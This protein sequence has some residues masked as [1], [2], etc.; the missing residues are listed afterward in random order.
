MFPVLNFL[1]RLTLAIALN[2]TLTI[3]AIILTDRVN[4]LT[5]SPE[6]GISEVT[7][8][9]TLDEAISCL[10]LIDPGSKMVEKCTKVVAAFYHYLDRMGMYNSF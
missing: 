1:H 5:D 2:A 7:L 10:P 3:I 8:R 6:S 4:G 9:A